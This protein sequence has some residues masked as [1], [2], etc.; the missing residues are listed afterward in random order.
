MICETVPMEDEIGG[1][2]YRYWLHRDLS[3][4]GDEGLVFVMLNP[5]TA[6]EVNDDPSVRRCM[7]FGRRW[8]YRELTVVN[9]F[10]LRATR[11]DDLRRHGNEAIGE[12]NDEVLCWMR[13]HPATSMIVAA[14]GNHGTHLNRDAAVMSIIQPAMALRITKPGC[15]AHPLYLP[16]SARPV[17]YEHRHLSARPVPYEHR[18]RGVDGGALSD[19]PVPIRRALSKLGDDIRDARRRRRIPMALLAERASISRTTL[20]NIEKGDAGVS[21]G[22]YAR[23]LFSLGLLDRLA[24]LA[25]ARH[26]DTGLAIERERLPKRIRRRRLWR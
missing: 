25:D 9:L 15:P 16:L 22:N 13:Q 12:R 19:T 4:A 23:A 8:G 14:W 26:D 20:T 3:T 2:R 11:P 24:D 7:A 17:P 21:L 18:H 6:D 10:A 1:L 5:S